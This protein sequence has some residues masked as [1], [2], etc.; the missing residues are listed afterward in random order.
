MALASVLVHVRRALLLF[1]IVLG[2]AALATSVSRTPR[3]AER[4]PRST[5]PSATPEAVPQ[6]DP[7]APELRLPGARGSRS[8]TLESG[9]AATLFVAV[10]EAGRVDLPTLGLSS[11]AEPLTPARFEL[12]TDDPRRH[13]V[14]FTPAAGGESRRFGRIVV[15]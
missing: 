13:S 10:P 15:R 14:R 5:P 8:V 12:L 7:D 3:Q 2:L 4:A 9:E 11:A 1:A 6:T